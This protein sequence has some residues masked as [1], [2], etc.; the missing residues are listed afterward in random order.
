MDDDEAA[1]IDEGTLRETLMKRFLRLR[2]SM[3]KDWYYSANWI[4]SSS[5]EKSAKSCPLIPSLNSKGELI[6][7]PQQVFDAQFNLV[8]SFSWFIQRDEL[9]NQFIESP[10]LETSFRN[11]PTW[12]ASLL[13]AAHLATSL[14]KS[15]DRSCSW[16]KLFTHVF[17]VVKSSRRALKGSK[18]L[19]IPLGT[20]ELMDDGL[21]NRD[22]DESDEEDE[23]Q[24]D[25]EDE[26]GEE[27]G[28]SDEDEE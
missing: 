6:A 22:S 27:D 20:V 23:N 5:N 28:E 12:S 17:S 24:E 7:D 15:P 21:P 13:I 2:Q 4:T 1:K 19:S 25:N 14:P 3:V 8:S 10:T 26:S 18:S 9:K 11:V 16:S